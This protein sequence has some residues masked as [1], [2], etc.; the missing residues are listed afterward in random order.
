MCVNVM[1]LEASSS[2]PSPKE[3]DVCFRISNVLVDVEC[4]EQQIGST[5]AV[6][7]SYDQELGSFEIINTFLEMSTTFVRLQKAELDTLQRV[8]DYFQ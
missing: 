7:G 4:L 8:R 1:G 2:C 3:K 5:L 6:V